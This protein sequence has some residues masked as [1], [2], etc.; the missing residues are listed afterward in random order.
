M[1]FRTDPIHRLPPTTASLLR[2]A[3]V[4]PSIPTCLAELVHN[5][6]DAAAS[7]IDLSYDLDRWTVACHDNGCGIARADLSHLGRHRYLTSKLDN[8]DTALGR[9]STLGF[10]GEALASLAD[11]GLLEVVTL[12]A[13]DEQTWELL[14]S[15]GA[16][17]S[18]QPATKERAGIGT[19]VWVRDI[20]AKVGTVTAHRCA[21]RQPR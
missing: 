3:V 8:T 9:I 4:L 14:A 17:I 21:N 16:T 11:V 7:K 13:E 6:I 19:S 20:F 5:S 12:S 10:R 1:T 18:L 2:S 15:E